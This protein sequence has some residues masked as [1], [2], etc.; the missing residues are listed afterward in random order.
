M[1]CMVGHYHFHPPKL[2]FL[3]MP[4]EES[5]P[6]WSLLNP[7]VQ[8]FPPL[9]CYTPC[10]YCSLVVF[11]LICNLLGTHIDKYAHPS[12]LTDH[13]LRVGTAS[14]VSWH[15]RLFF[16]NILSYICVMSVRLIFLRQ[17]FCKGIAFV[18]FIFITKLPSIGIMPNIHKG[19][20][21]HHR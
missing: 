19:V 9:K 5:L 13:F 11:I 14:N 7:S 17:N 1:K 21:V 2:L 12:H 18:I 6:I 15:L 16:F 20:P 10:A 8:L 4:W 3:S